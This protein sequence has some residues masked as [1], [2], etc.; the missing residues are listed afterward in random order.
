MIVLPPTAAASSKEGSIL[1]KVPRTIRKLVGTS[2][3]ACTHIIPVMENMLNPDTPKTDCSKLL[4]IPMLAL[5]R[6]IHA[7]AYSIRGIAIGLRIR[8]YAVTRPGIVVLSNNNTA[9]QAMNKLRRVAAI[10]K[11]TLRHIVI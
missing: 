4:N 2:I 3:N 1:L 7:I 8:V 10:A 5:R 11:Y 9:R 6:R